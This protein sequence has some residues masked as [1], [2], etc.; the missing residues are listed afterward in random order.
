MEVRNTELECAK[1]ILFYENI[2]KDVS[3]WICPSTTDYKRDSIIEV[4]SEGNCLY[5]NLK[6]NEDDVNLFQVVVLN[7]NDESEESEEKSSDC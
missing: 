7:L 1:P 4:Y 5:G 3:I 2:K 6:I